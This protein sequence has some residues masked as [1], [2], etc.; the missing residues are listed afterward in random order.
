MRQITKQL[1]D[2]YRKKYRNKLMSDVIKVANETN[3]EMFT[4]VNIMYDSLIAQFYNS[5]SPDYYIRHG[6]VRPGEGGTNLYN[7]KQ[8]RKRGGYNPTLTID[9][10]GA[11]MASENYKVSADT[12]LDFVMDGIR[13]PSTR[14]TPGLYWS[15]EYHSSLTGITYTGTIKEMFDIFVNDFDDIAGKVFFEK[16]NALGWPTPKGW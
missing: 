10:S 3:N 5:Y 7:G 16:W 14:R 4:E 6:A 15:G 13:F 1:A 2:A 11:E 12:V 9:F 8:F